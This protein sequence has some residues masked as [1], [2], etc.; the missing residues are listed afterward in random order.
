MAC[1][2]QQVSMGLPE[3]PT[4]GQRQGKVLLEEGTLELPLSWILKNNRS[5]LPRDRGALIIPLS[6]L[7][8]KLRMV[9][10]WLTSVLPAEFHGSRDFTCLVH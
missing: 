1:D 2:V 3:A 9:A 4:R 10:I 8:L 6:P 7:L 5:L